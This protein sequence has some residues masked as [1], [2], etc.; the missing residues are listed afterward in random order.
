MGCRDGWQRRT[1]SQGCEQIFSSADRKVLNA[2]QQGCERKV[3]AGERELHLRLHSYRPQY[4]QIGLAQRA[5]ASSLQ[6]PPERVM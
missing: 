6:S 5:G 3:D 4:L 2:I 1:H